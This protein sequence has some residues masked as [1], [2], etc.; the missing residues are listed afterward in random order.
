MTDGAR[1]AVVLGAGGAVGH[2]YHCGVLAA[3]QDVLGFDASRADRLVGTSAGSVVATLLA[4][5]VSAADLAAPSLDRERS[6]QATHLLA[7]IPRSS[8]PPGQVAAPGWTHLLRPAAPALLARLALRPDRARPGT[9]AAAALPEGRISH[10]HVAGHVPAL[11]G[12]DWPARVWVPA[13]RLDDGARVVFGRPGAPRATLVDAV[14]ASCAIPGWYRPVTVDGARYVDGGVH[15]PTNLDV[16]ADQAFDLVVVSSPM[17]VA[18][19]H[20]WSPDLPPRLALA[21]LLARERRQ[22]E[23]AGT[24][25]VTFQ[26]TAEDQG[27]MGLRFL[28]PSRRRDVVRQAHASVSDRLRDPEVRRRLQPLAVT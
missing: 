6:E 4:G 17:S 9:V 27:A 28:D 8:P 16:L 22:V 7:G 21:A 11:F 24:P 23:D 13:V 14:A 18:P 20:R 25:V 5:G 19:D 12:D 3:L 2:A 10:D 26:P 15:S 1:V